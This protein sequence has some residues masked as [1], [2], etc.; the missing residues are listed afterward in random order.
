M[1][2]KNK[3]WLYP[4]L[5]MV[6]VL[7]STNGCK[8]NADDQT[9]E[10]DAP[11]SSITIGD[12]TYSLFLNQTGDPNAEAIQAQIVNTVSNYTINFY[13]TFDSENKPETIKTISYIRSGNDTT[14]YFTVDPV[15]KKPASQF[16][17]VNG[18]KLPTI[19][20]Y[21][22][23]T[24][25]ENALQISVYDYNWGSNTGILKSEG[26]YEN[27]NGNT[28]EDIIYNGLKIMTLTNDNFDDFLL[29]FASG[30]ALIA[31]YNMFGTAVLAAISGISAP[32]VAA[33]IIGTAIYLI[34]SDL[35]A[36][37][38]VPG[39]ITP[40]PETP[41]NNPIP[42]SVNPT[43]NLPPCNCDVVNIIFSASMDAFGSIAIW[44]VSGGVVPYTYA[45]GASAYQ[46]AAIFNGPYPDGNYSIKVKDANGCPGYKMVQL[47]STAPTLSIGQS[48]Q[49][50]IIAYILQPGDPGY[51]ANI[52]HGL[53]AAPSDQSTGIQWYNGSYT[54][55]GATGVALG[56]GRTNT[57]TIISSQGSGTYAAALC[58]SIDLGGY[59]G[60]YLPSKD[61]LL[62]LY[63]NRNAI[64]GFSTNYY[65]SS[66]ESSNMFAF[67]K[68]FGPDGEELTTGKNLSYSVRAVRSFWNEY[69]K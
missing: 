10:P 53:I 12:F 23:F 58:S 38:V 57:N 54:T 65:W 1:K 48:Y 59:Y 34:T 36:A 43:P 32:F 21:K 69:K 16:F 15:T 24:S 31:S 47:Q 3:I 41:I 44:G 35:C 49:G 30:C 46:P 29:T 33:A 6:F 39:P 64:G 7:F 42:P 50:G 55:T 17:V 2:Q 4:L 14:V 61:E 62:K 19:I 28:Y 37:E 18:N 5:L 60:W 8:K 66:S 51:D 63:L 68:S 9:L 20:N 52:P 27:I 40:T 13:G 56:T 22:Y 11:K 67:A 26:I 45:I 25:N